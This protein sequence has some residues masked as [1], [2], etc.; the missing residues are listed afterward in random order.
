M[1]DIPN[2]RY[3]RITNIH[4]VN[5]KHD[6]EPQRERNPINRHYTK[7]AHL[8]ESKWRNGCGWEWKQRKKPSWDMKFCLVRYIF[9]DL[10]LLRIWTHQSG[11][12]RYWSQVA[13]TKG[14]LIDYLKIYCISI[15]VSGKGPFIRLILTRLT[16]L[17]CP[18]LFWL[19]RLWENTINIMLMG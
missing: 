9:Q 17:T 8:I 2:F 7:H 16:A 13:Q 6:K 14:A 1:G 12:P 3:T 11:Q 4:K 10:T 18:T 19:I 15:S 5:Y